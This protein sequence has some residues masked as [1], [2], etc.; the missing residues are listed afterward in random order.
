MHCSKRPVNMVCNVLYADGCSEHIEYRVRK[1]MN[2]F[3]ALIFLF[4]ER[5]FIN[6]SFKKVDQCFARVYYPFSWSNRNGRHFE[7]EGPHRPWARGRSR[8]LRS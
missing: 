2:K 7:L 3:K 5:K 4:Q 1:K 6:K 8:S